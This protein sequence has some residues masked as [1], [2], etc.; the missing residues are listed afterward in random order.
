M[1]RDCGWLVRTPVVE[2][3]F[4]SNSSSAAAMVSGP[5]PESCADR[6][7]VLAALASDALLPNL[8]LAAAFFVLESETL[9]G[10]R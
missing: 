7:P 6:A 1:S 9:R 5:T 3:S 8:P 10:A 4:S 2:R